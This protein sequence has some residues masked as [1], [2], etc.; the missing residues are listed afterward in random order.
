MKENQLTDSFTTKEKLM[1]TSYKIFIT[2]GII[3]LVI[4]AYFLT[5]VNADNISIN[6]PKIITLKTYE[7]GYLPETNRIF[8][9]NRQTETVDY[10]LSDT[11]SYAVFTLVANNVKRDYETSINGDKKEEKKK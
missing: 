4:F 5:K 3:S 10:I 11:L 2:F 1:K 7:V 8:L 6:K 9:L